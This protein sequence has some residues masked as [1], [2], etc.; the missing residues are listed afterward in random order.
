MNKTSADVADDKIAELRAVIREGNQ[1]LSDMKRERKAAA[2]LFQKLV[3]ERVEKVLNKEVE[4]G[5]KNFM[6]AS[7]LATDQAV[8][9]IFKQFDSLAEQLLNGTKS[10]QRKGNVSIP[11]IVRARVE[12]EPPPHS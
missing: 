5:L 11:A 4:E 6:E 8:E 3:P 9:R 1:L 10:D 7:R 2:D 12:S